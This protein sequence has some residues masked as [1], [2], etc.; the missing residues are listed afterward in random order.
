MS[1]AAAARDTE[2]AGEPG[3]G[4]GAGVLV[5]VVVC[6]DHH[7]V[8]QGL[9]MVLGAEPD[10]EVVGVAG[11]V[12]EVREMAA[13]FR[14]HVVL[15][16]YGLPDGDGVTA[17]AAIKAA[18]PDVQVV[19]LTSFMDED[20]LVAAI[21]AGCSGYVT[22]HKGGEEL[23]AAVRLAAA[24]EAL[25]SPDMLARLLPRLRR[26]RHGL[27]PRHRARA[28]P[29]AGPGGPARRSRAGGQRHRPRHGSGDLAPG[30]HRRHGT[31]RAMTTWGP[32]PGTSNS[33]LTTSK[34]LR[35]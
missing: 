13:A 19:M 31:G 14:P 25:V 30:R 7:V 22:K 27:G 8:A 24:G 12:A 21:Q 34:P 11:S 4:H 6:D 18:Q 3:L 17:T 9:A 35:R 26:A 5:R 32:M 1:S 23:T 2:F 20:I 33:S 28:G 10:I 16:D 15:M 29:G